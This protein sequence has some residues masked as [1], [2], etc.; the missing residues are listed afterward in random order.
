MKCKHYKGEGYV[1]HLSDGQELDLCH[2]CE[3]LLLGDMKLIELQENKEIS[4]I[5]DYFF[6]EYIKKLDK[7]KN[8]K[9]QEIKRDKK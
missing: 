5:K 7:F 4:L 1:Y 3:T 9:H 6:Q 2:E 8:K